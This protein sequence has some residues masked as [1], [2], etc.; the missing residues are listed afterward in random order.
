MTSLAHPSLCQ[1]T[2]DQGVARVLFNC[3]QSKI[4]AKER[5]LLMAEEMAWKDQDDYGDDLLH[6][7]EQMDT[8]TLPDVE[9]INIQEEIEWYMR[10]F[11]LN[12]LEEVHTT[13]QLLPETLFLA[14]NIL[15]RY[16]SKRV[17]YKRHYQLVGCCSLLIAAKYGDR[18]DKVPTIKELIAVCASLYDEDMFRQMEGHILQTIDWVI[19]HPTVDSFLQVA[20]LNEPCDRELEHMA[21]YIAEMSLYHKEF[22]SKLSSDV[23]RS[24]LALARVVLGRFQPGHDKWAAQY[25]SD[26]LLTLSTAIYQPPQPLAHKYAKESFSRS[27]SVL[28]QYLVTR[29]AIAKG[30]HPPSSAHWLWAHDGNAPLTPAESYPG[31]PAKS[32]HMVKSGNTLPTPPITPEYH[33]NAPEGGKGNVSA[34]FHPGSPTPSPERP[35]YCHNH[36]EGGCMCTEDQ[37]A[38]QEDD[39]V[40]SPASPEMSKASSE[41]RFA[42]QYYG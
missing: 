22:V 23:A 12:F 41:P 30:Y 13:F 20:L 9:A 1:A 42:Y 26:T 19:G 2:N 33:L 4:S 27:S 34:A 5:Q 14:V 18:K 38:Y 16:C 8:Q 3:D 28:E 35:W 11:L 36:P 10:A 29:D 40:M 31:T 24:S 21:S 6:H 37:G 25:N 17:V 7:M 15:D 39:E 32:G